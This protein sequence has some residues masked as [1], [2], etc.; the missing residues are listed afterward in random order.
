MLI[1]RYVYRGNNDPTLRL[2]ILIRQRAVRII[3]NDRLPLLDIIRKPSKQSWSRK[4]GQLL[5]WISCLTAA[6]IF[7]A[8]QEQR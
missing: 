8:N 1:C 2:Q 5:E 3:R 6:K 4:F 7:V